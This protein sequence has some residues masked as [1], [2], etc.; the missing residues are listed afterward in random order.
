MEI[1]VYFI[2]N[3][4]FLAAAESSTADTVCEKK[5]NNS[6]LQM[7]YTIGGEHAANS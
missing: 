2:K 7:T 4:L 6:K 1:F 5:N 3:S